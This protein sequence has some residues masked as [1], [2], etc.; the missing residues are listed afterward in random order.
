MKRLS[1]VATVAALAAAVP[2]H[3]LAATFKGV[4]VGRTGGAIAV[5]TAKGTVHTLKGHARIGAV[6]RVSGARVRVVGRAHR[7]HVH[8][9]VVRRVGRTTFVAAGRSLLAIHGRRALAAAAAPTP[10]TGDVVNATVRIDDDELENEEME[11]VGR[12]N[13]VTVVASIV[14]VGNGTITVSVN[15]QMLTINLPAGLA[16]PASVVG[17]NVTLT[18]RL[19]GAQPVVQDDD[20]DDDDNAG[21]GNADDDNAGPGNVDDDDQG[22]N[23]DDDDNSGPGGGGHGGHDG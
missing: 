23:E 6:V 14:A 18:V 21:P 13:A 10:T 7:A 9:V 17:Q 2:G 5:A 15:G 16:L 1:L 3:A 4:V 11:E 20:D 22:E 19:A 12:Q 8:G